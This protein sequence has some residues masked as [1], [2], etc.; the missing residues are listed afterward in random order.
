MIEEVF[1]QHDVTRA[2]AF[3][4]T[5]AIDH[6]ALPA[7]APGLEGWKRARAALFTAFPDLHIALEEQIADGEKLANR[8]TMQGTHHGEFMGMP[9]TGKPIMVTGIDVLRFAHGKIVEHWANADMLGM[10]QQLGVV[11]APGLGG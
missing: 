10:L 9:A 11:P 6:A 1:N 7:Q 4:A 8:F 5:D 3:I 2:E